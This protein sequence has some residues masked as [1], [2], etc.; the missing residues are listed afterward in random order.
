VKK[1][2]ISLDPEKKVKLVPEKI[3]VISCDLTF[4]EIEKNI[5][6]GTCTV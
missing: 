4:M 1:S 5:L 6:P 2:F 3:T